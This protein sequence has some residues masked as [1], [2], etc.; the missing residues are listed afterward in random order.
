MLDAILEM[1]PN[2][3]ISIEDIRPHLQHGFPWHQPALA[4]PEL[5]EPQAWWEHIKASVLSRACASLGYAPTTAWE[6]AE[7]TRERYLDLTHWTLFDDVLRT[8][9]KLSALGWRHLIVSNHVPEL[10]QIVVS[11]GLGASIDQVV[12]SSR[13]GYEKPHPE[14]YRMALELA[15]RPEL[16]C[17]VGDNVE[18]DV[19]GAERAGV[20]AILVRREDPRVRYRCSDLDELVGFLHD[21]EPRATSEG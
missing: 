16:V 5:N 8:L 3:P 14:I 11:L 15:G 21:L 9:P 10:E 6:L 2:S 1:E 7:R 18:S 12:V 19:L 4:H 17:M 13:V 20:P